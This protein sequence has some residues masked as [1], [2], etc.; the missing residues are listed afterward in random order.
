MAVQAHASRRNE[1]VEVLVDF[2]L[3]RVLSELHQT[4]LLREETEPRRQW[5]F[6]RN[7]CSD[8]FD[9]FVELNFTRSVSGERKVQL[10]VQVTSYKGNPGGGPEPN[11]SYEVR[12]TLMESLGLRRWLI[13]EKTPGRTVHIT[14]GP[15]AYAYG[16]IKLAKDNSFDL[17]L[18]PDYSR[19]Q[20]D[21]FA[22]LTDTLRNSRTE[23]QA[24]ATLLSAT[25]TKRSLL[26]AVINGMVQDL[27]NWIEGG[28][29]PN[30]MANLQA[31]LLGKLA[32][33]R[34]QE[35]SRAVGASAKG[36]ANIKP[37]FERAVLEGKTSD[38]LMARTI[39][40]LLA[41]NP[42]LTVALEAERS[43]PRW[44][45]D[46][47]QAP[48]ANTE[49]AEYVNHLWLLGEPERLV[50]RRLLLRVH[51]A[52]DVQYVQ[53]T[54]IPGLT[55]HNLY[56]GDHTAEQVRAVV[57]RIVRACDEAGIVSSDQLL[58]HL[59]GNRGRALLKASRT[60]ELANGTE[61][62]PSFVYVEEALRGDYQLVSF[63]KTNLPPPI[64]YHAS[65]GATARP[66]QNMKVVL[67][68]EGRPLAILK[69]K[70]FREQEFPRRAKEEGY[71]GLTTRFV[72]SDGF[73][74]RYPNVPMIM[75]VDMATS[76]H[77]PEYAVR[78]LVTAGWDAAFSISELRSLIE[79]ND[80][81]K[82]TH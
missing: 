12:E 24:R 47:L 6:Q 82:K 29:S 46:T 37:A 15:P 28:L 53:D 39:P 78:R 63:S 41:R 40:R 69:A 60:L 51:S 79:S 59:S 2:I 16:W 57:A 52:K 25:Q 34:I 4:G 56:G 7:D 72:Y 14:L 76:F 3:R 42:F 48:T 68:K 54:G 32:R 70:Y 62:R 19:G 49:I 74:E 55:E 13:E 26:G 17:S 73:R 5:P 80:R 33:D 35:V 77:P 61:V 67:S 38:P 27:Q 11:K 64:G 66:Y 81:R 44:T 50:V 71:V 1:Q 45:R 30:P 31:T 23:Q 36:G 65:F 58:A 21:L 10:W 43:W 75:F 22:E 18:Y 9:S 20:F 8:V